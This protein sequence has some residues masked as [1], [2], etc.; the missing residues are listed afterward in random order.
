MAGN[1]RGIDEHLV[2][3]VIL[4]ARITAR[5][6]LD[7]SA[8]RTQL[9]RIRAIPGRQA[10]K[11]VLIHKKFVDAGVIHTQAAISANWPDFNLWGF[12]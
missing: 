7:F 1:D 6:P 8:G 2:I 11:W 12:R 5:L 10:H 3:D 9:N 4:V